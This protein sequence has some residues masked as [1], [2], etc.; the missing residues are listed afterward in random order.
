MSEDFIAHFLNTFEREYLRLDRKNFQGIVTEWKKHCI[1]FGQV[2]RVQHKGKAEEA[3]FED[4]NSEGHLIYRLPS[5][6][7]GTLIS[8][9]MNLLK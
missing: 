9:D 1:Q 6:S 3:F 7:V 5:G 8:G 2:I 4:I